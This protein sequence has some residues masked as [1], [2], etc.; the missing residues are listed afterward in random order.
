[1]GSSMQGDSKLRLPVCGWCRH[2]FRKPRQRPWKLFEI[3][4]ITYL[5]IPASL[6]MWQMMVG[7]GSELPR[8]VVNGHLWIA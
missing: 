1:M 8:R 2:L 6:S 5:D 3:S 4:Q 7:T